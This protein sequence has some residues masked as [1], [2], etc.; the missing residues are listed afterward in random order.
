[1]TQEAI[2]M[3]YSSGAFGCNSPQALINTL[4]YNNYLRFGLRGGKEQSDLKYGNVVLKK[5][6]EGKE[7]LEFNTERRTK[8]RTSENPINRRSVKPR[9]Y[10][11]LSAGAQRNPAYKLYNV[12]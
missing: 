3:L 11:N 8:T 7:Y 9:V 1:M 12:Q 6:T 10:E 5:D 2:E 4:C